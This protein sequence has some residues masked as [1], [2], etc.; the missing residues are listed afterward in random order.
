MTGALDGEA[1]AARLKE[2]TERSQ[3]VAAEFAARHGADAASPDPD[4]LGIGKAFLDMTARMMADPARL[5]TAQAE[6]ARQYAQLW[7]DTAERMMGAAQPAPVIE[8]EPGDRRFRDDAW[9]ENFVFDFIKQSYLLSSRFL[10]GGVAEAEGGDP[11][12]AEKVAFYTRQ[13]V[14]AMAP[15]NF[16]ATNPKV[17]RE[18]IDSKGEN[19]L[20]GFENLLRD[21]EA[22]KGRLRIAQTDMSAFEV[23]RN[24]A[25]DARQGGAAHRADGADPVCADDG[26]RPRDAAPDRAALDQQVLHS[27]SCA[28]KLLRALGGGAGPHR[29]RDLLGQPGR[30]ALRQGLRGLYGRGAAWRPSTPSSASPARGAPTPSAIAWA[31]RC[32]R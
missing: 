31:A 9:R 14:D 7:Q 23:G 28:G 2:I 13:F 29:V 4:P 11:H 18:T 6:L 3:R 26:D 17:L 5:A 20:R 19:L 30:P 16:A 15:T 12:D 27:R 24:V 1:L 25:V 22:G 10:L 8:P 32:W 21:L